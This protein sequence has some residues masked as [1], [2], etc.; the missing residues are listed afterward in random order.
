[1]EI[2]ADEIVDRIPTD[3]LEKE[4]ATREDRSGINPDMVIDL[5]EAIRDGNLNHLRIVLDKWMP[6]AGAM[7]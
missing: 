2:Y 7:I 1:V 4:L 6:G 3:V 5:L